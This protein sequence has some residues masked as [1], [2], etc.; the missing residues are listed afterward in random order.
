MRTDYEVQL[1][2]LANDEFL[3]E[4][5]EDQRKPE[6]RANEQVTLTACVEQEEL[7]AEREDKITNPVCN[8]KEVEY[9]PLGS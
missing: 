1:E 5:S 6:N 9:L 8:T 7:H 2:F 3:K 4:E